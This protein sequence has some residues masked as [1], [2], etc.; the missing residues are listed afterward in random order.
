ML[1]VAASGS[2]VGKLNI[3]AQQHIV[4]VFLNVWCCALYLLDK[5]FNSHKSRFNLNGL[6][7]K[8]T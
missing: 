1:G 2:A 3:C 7:T 8:S 6:L 4:V 5:L